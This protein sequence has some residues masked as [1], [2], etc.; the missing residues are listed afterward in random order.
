MCLLPTKCSF[1]LL[2]KVAPR[3]LMARKGRRI[4]GLDQQRKASGRCGPV[5]KIV[6]HLF[7]GSHRK[8]DAIFGCPFLT[9]VLFS[10]HPLLWGNTWITEKASEIRLTDEQ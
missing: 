8:E 1:S 2:I 10:S 5:G 3:M 6:I 9:K 4:T 7:L